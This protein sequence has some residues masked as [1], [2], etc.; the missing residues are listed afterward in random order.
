MAE[1]LLTR[2]QLRAILFLRAEPLFYKHRGEERLHP[3]CPICTPVDG[4]THVSSIQEE[5]RVISY[6]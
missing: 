5:D 1:I 4:L 3:V 2:N 6:K